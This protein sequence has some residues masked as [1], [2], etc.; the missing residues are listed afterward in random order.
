M[1]NEERIMK[2]C[3]LILCV[4]FIICSVMFT[5][6]PHLHEC[7]DSECATCAL[8]KATCDVLP[9]LCLG[10]FVH[11][12]LMDCTPCFAHFAGGQ[13]AREATPVGRKVKLSD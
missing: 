3:A 2:R 6:M 11:L 7:A 10:A 5:F 8:L 4:I 13:S 1:R 9:F 12:S